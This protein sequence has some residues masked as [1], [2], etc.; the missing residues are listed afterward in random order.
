VFYYFDGEFITD[1]KK[2][3]GTDGQLAAFNFIQQ[4]EIEDHIAIKVTGQFTDTQK[5]SAINDTLSYG[6][7]KL[8]AIEAASIQN[9]EEV[10]TDIAKTTESSK[11]ETDLTS[12]VALEAKSPDTGVED[13]FNVV[14]ILVLTAIVSVLTIFAKKLSCSNDDCD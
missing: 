3:N 4:S 1:E 12:E 13:K 14:I 6:I 11:A 8:Y 5:V 7:F 9:A 10:S 2:L